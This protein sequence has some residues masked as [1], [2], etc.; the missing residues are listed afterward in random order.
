M[1][2]KDLVA[3]IIFLAFLI[4]FMGSW[5][6]VLA[7]SGTGVEHECCPANVFVLIGKMGR[8][9]RY[10]GFKPLRVLEEIK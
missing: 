2:V 5:F 7:Y 9:R 3:G 10:D 4:W 1:K 8:A 6:E